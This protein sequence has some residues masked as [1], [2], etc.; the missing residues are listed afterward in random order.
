[1]A[2]INQTNKLFTF[3]STAD[4]PDAQYFRREMER[5]LKYVDERIGGI[6]ETAVEEAGI[7]PVERGGFG[8]DM[9]N[10]PQFA[11]PYAPNPGRFGWF[12]SSGWGISLLSKKTL[13]EW[14]AALGITSSTFAAGTVA[15]R[16]SASSGPLEQLTVSAGLIVVGNQLRISD[17]YPGQVSITTLGSITTGTWNATTIATNRGGTGFT[18]YASG[19]LLYGNGGGTLSKLAEPGLPGYLLSWVGGIPT[20]VQLS[21]VAVTAGTGTANQ[22]LVNGTTGSAQTGVLTFTL[23]QSIDTAASVQFSRL[24]LGAVSAGGGRLLVR[25]DNSGPAFSIYDNSDAQ[26]L[27][28]DGSYNLISTDAG[29]ASRWSI[30]NAGAVVAVSAEISAIGGVTPGTAVFT[31]VAINGGTVINPIRVTGSGSDTQIR[32]QNTSTGGHLW[33]LGSAGAGSGLPSGFY[34]YNYTS[35]FVGFKVDNANG[36]SFSSTIQT[37]SPSGGTAQPWKLGNYTAGVAVQA[38]KVRVEIN[39][40]PYDLLTA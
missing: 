31:D 35:G 27:R 7:V 17:T 39:G 8:M 4:T 29:A 25:H 12:I 37:A 15:G 30:S 19:D 28:V 9:S 1:M 11:V 32:V 26:R 33:A 24:M 6:S 36:I 13:V 40:T 20:A 16:N 21:T 18:T 22:V 3:Q 10:I 34:L 5:I 23:P 14:Q 2:L 38:G